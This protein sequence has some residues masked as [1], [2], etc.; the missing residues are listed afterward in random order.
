[1]F[2][3]LNGNYFKPKISHQHQ[4][5]GQTPEVCA[6]KLG[7]KLAFFVSFP[8]L[9]VP[10]SPW[11]KKGPGQSQKSKGRRRQKSY[12]EAFQSAGPAF[13]DQALRENRLICLED[14]NP[15][16]L[17]RCPVTTWAGCTMTARQCDRTGDGQPPPWEWLR[18]TQKFCRY[19]GCW[20]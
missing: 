11:L 13:W 6:S 17:G 14:K 8:E 15:L 18:I 4:V 19:A 2:W 12:P 10:S 3:R 7:T 16:A 1:M 5:H 9:P 20:M